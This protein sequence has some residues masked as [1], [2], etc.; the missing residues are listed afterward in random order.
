MEEGSEATKKEIE[1]GEHIVGVIIGPGGRDIVEL[2]R[3]TGANI[4]I[5]KKGVFVPGT[6]NRVVTVTGTPSAVQRAQYL[7]QQRISQEEVKIARQS[8]Q[9]VQPMSQ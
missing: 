6:R 4:Q 5:S 3:Y 7:I 8:T 9:Q 1:I 2:Q